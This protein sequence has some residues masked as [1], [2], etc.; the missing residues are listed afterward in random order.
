MPSS[1]RGDVL[2]A[3][4]DPSIRGLLS[5]IVHRL[6]H[7]PVAVADGHEAGRLLAGGRFNAILLDLLLPERSGLELLDGL[8]ADD[9]EQLRKVI[10][11]TTLPPDACRHRKQIAAFLR[12]PF[13]LDELTDALIN[14]CELP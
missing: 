6:E 13:T 11:I 8:E 1:T 5:A 4:G 12:K 7:N 10:V 9:P 3:D 14:C 2:I